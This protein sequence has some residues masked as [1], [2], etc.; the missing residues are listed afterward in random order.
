[1]LQKIRDNSRGIFAKIFIAFVIAVF[2]LF[3]VETIVGSFLASNASVEVNG[4]ELSETQIENAFQ[5]RLQQMV[6][7]MSE[8]ELE[9]LDEGEVRQQTIDEMIQ[10]ELLVQ[11]AA[12]TGLAVSPSAID[13]QIAATAEFQVDGVF[14][15][16]RAQ[17]MLTSV[18]YTAASYRAALVRDG[19]LNQLINGYTT[20]TF[21]T[22]AEE[23]QLAAL[24]QQ[25]RDFRYLLINYTD[26]LME[27]EL[28]EDEIQ[29]FYDANQEAFISEELVSVQYL[30]LNRDELMD[31]D[32]VSDEDIRA[33]YQQEVDEEAALTERRASH[34]L[35][36]ASTPEEFSA[37]TALAEELKARLD[38]GESFDDLAREFSDDAG[39]SD[40]GGDV[41]YTTGENF[42]EEFEAALRELSPDEV[43]GPVTT[44]FG[45]HLIKLTELIESETES[46]EEASP[47]IR[48]ELARE[49]AN[50]R[51]EEMAEELN[52]LAFEAFDLT[53]PAQILGLEIMETE[54]F[55]R[56]GGSGI[57]AN[58]S[59]IDTAFSA[60]VLEDGLNSEL[61]RIADG[62]SAVL[63]LLEHREPAVQPLDEVSAMIEIQLRLEKVQEMARTTGETI[64]GTLNNDGNI[65]TLLQEQGISWST[66]N[67]VGRDSSEV[68][69]E[70]LEWI[71]SLP[72]PGD[73]TVSRAGRLLRTGAYAVAE[74]QAVNPGSVDDLDESEVLSMREF[75]VQQHAVSDF[76]A[77]LQNLE[78]EA[79]IRR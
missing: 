9:D 71:F 49:N 55:S 77:L 22:P 54:P 66:M 43:S 17:A 67:D 24:T 56:Q 46:L 25:T 21:I 65:S 19:L 11:E 53:E 60:D 45:V 31:E 51:Y 38:A 26:Q 34:I 52:N 3:G 27:I 79:S 6:A 61:V 41:G 44:E 75:V 13:R 36:E 63:R 42:V 37:A 47:R 59:F 74:L 73:G 35:L 30:E 8:A 69:P 32:A 5:R 58:Q 70:L 76:D 64:L 39:S 28:S 78:A 72:E 20:S 40:F 15:N 68:G 12:A 16:E 7:E 14:N 57:S 62:R 33:R 10:Q 18:G 1:M 2:A 23:Q 4:V 48:T 50:S 29:A